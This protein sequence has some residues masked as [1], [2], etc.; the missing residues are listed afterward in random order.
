MDFRSQLD[1]I[2]MQHDEKLLKNVMN[3][4]DFNARLDLLAGRLKELDVV[5]TQNLKEFNNS[6]AALN[7]RNRESES[8]QA[9]IEKIGMLQNDVQLL[10]KQVKG[11]VGSQFVLEKQLYK[12]QN[13]LKAIS[14]VMTSN[15]ASKA[16][17]YIDLQKMK[18]EVNLLQIKLAEYS[19]TQED[20]T[21]KMKT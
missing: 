15:E 9:E 5:F 20:L 2:N 8:T 14:S 13:N 6:V 21:Q 4:E 17:L 10:Q 11:N 16:E 7:T 1:N 19:N 18:D 3:L 12:I